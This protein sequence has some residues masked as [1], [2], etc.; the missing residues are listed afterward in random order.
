MKTSLLL[1][2]LSLITIPW[3]AEVRA[4]ARAGV[5]A[6]S[7]NHPA[8]SLEIDARYGN[9]SFAPA[10]EGI[11]GGYGLH[12]VHIDVRRLFQNEQHTFWIG[13]G[14]SFV[15][16]NESSNTTWNVDT[17]FELR[18]K[19]RFEPF[20]AARFYSFRLPVFRDV[21]KGS[22]AVISVGVSMRLR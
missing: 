22:G 4:A 19:S 12:A 8:G 2:A 18:S 9:W 1:L 11:Q 3:R 15:S 7:D 6:G 5:F 10:Y 16:T 14:P 17:G 13:A 21:V 20:V